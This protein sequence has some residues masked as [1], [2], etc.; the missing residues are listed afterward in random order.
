MTIPLGAR[1]MLVSALAFALMTTC[2]K[3]AANRGIPLLE[4]VAARC[5]VSLVISYL[6]M[7]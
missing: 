4:I 6:L 1:Y 3:L 7:V 2:V 5:L